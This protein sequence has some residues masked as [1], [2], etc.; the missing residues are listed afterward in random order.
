MQAVRRRQQVLNGLLS[1]DLEVSLPAFGCFRQHHVSF[2][3]SRAYLGI[4][5]EPLKY[6]ACVAGRPLAPPA[7]S[8][9]L[10]PKNSDQQDFLSMK[11]RLLEFPHS[12]FCE[13]V[14]WALDFKGI[15]FK[16]VSLFPG[17]HVKVVRKFARQSTVPVLLDG[18]HV[19]QGSSEIMTYLDQVYPERPLATPGRD[20]EALE[21]E[22]ELDRTIGESIRRV[23]Y[24]LL[25]EDSDQVRHYFMHRSPWR[26]RVLFRLAYSSIKEKIR[27][28]YSIDAVGFDRAL[29]EFDDAIG[30]LDRL[31]AGKNHLLNDRFS[32]VD[33]TAASLLSFVCL[34]P[35]H[36]VPWLPLRNKDA[37]ELLARYVDRPT[38][39][40]VKRVYAKY[41]I[42]ASAAR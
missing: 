24:H 23:I 40:W 36:P 38:L 39:T 34:P 8:S 13:K 7:G 20:A 25:L 41:R 3:I 19:I 16:R 26:H 10:T 12:H 4:V 15:P 17:L 29:R 21:F 42:V 30:R 35:E 14:R 37:K 18:D 1:P 6:Q 5:P 9:L 33:I 31:V 2:L 11:R 27:A 22:K 28:K 32:R